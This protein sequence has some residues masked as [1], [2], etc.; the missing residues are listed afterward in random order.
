MADRKQRRQRQRR[1]LVD[2]INALLTLLVLGVLVAGGLVAYGAHTFYAGGPV[3]KDTNFVVQRGNNLASVGERL[4]EQGLIDNRYVFQLGALALKKQG[5]LKAGEYRL[6][7]NA[8]MFD[9]LKTLTEGK[10]VSISVTIP[11]GFTV[12]Q[13]VDR[14]NKSDKLTGTITVLP[15]EGSLLPET[16]E[17]DPGATR[18]SVLDRMEEAMK[19]KVAEVWDNR[20]PGVP[21]STPDQLVTLA[22]I[23]EKETPVPS[24]RAMIAGVYYNRLARHM[25]LQSDPTV[26]YGLTKGEGAGGRAP[27]RAELDQPTPYNT[28]QIDGLPP[29]P[30]AN[31]GVDALTAAAHPKSSNDVYFVAASLNPKDG[32]LFAATFAEHRK[33]VAKLRAVQK[34]QAAADAE[35]AKDQ[36]EEQQAAEA[37]DPTVAPP[38]GAAPAGGTTPA[39]PAASDQ[40]SAGNQLTLD[41]GGATPDTAPATAPPADQGSTPD[42]AAPGSDTTPA[43]AASTGSDVPVPMPANERPGGE[44]NA[45]A[46][47]AEPAAAPAVKP[48]TRPARP[49][50]TTQDVFGG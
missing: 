14:L 46:A 30:I 9:I 5:Q 26:V 43:A 4:E 24:E 10:P 20:D 45:V 3:G 39:A 38:S 11:E 6:A 40:Q 27:T 19:A 50:P 17:F 32:H 47:P 15:P 23:V 7:A 8:S 21:L 13:V 29:G 28:Y 2:F 42:T 41:G 22:S 34:E 49:R 33:N 12:A 31:P 35:A 16:Y 36:L 44:G 37:G 48:P 25:R 1:G 18:Q